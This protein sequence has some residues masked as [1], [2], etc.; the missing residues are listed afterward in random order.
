MNP[1][2]QDSSASRLRTPHLRF[3][4]KIAV[5]FLVIVTFLAGL[6]VL[7]PFLVKEMAGARIDR[8]GA[9]L[10]GVFRHDDIRIDGPSTL[11]LPSLLFQDPD[12]IEVSAADIKISVDPLA[13]LTGGR[14]ITAVEVGRVRIVAG[15]REEPIE[16]AKFA[17]RLMSRLLSRG[18]TVSAA[19]ETAPVESMHEPPRRSMLP[20]IRINS[21][22]GR[23]DSSIVSGE[24]SSGRANLAPEPGA[25]D[26]ATRTGRIE[27]TFR[28]SGSTTA[29]RIDVNASVGPGFRP[30][31]VVASVSPPVSMRLR[32]LAVQA[33]SVTWKKR[34]FRI[35]GIKASLP[36]SKRLPGEISAGQLMVRFKPLGP[37]DVPAARLVPS[38]IERFF[39]NSLML[40]LNAVAIQELRIA[41]P[42]L[43][44]AI[45]AG[46]GTP[47]PAVAS[48]SDPGTGSLPERITRTFGS[49]SQR[50]E[51][52]R[53]S[54]SGLAQKYTGTRLAVNGAT[55][56]YVNTPGRKDPISDHTLSNLDLVVERGSKSALLATLMFESPESSSLRNEATLMVGL[57]GSVDIGLSASKL[58]LEPY[59]ML[60]PAW[61][62]IDRSTAI[63]DTDFRMKIQDGGRIEASGRMNLADAGILIREIATDAMTSVKLGVSGT[64]TVDG[65]AGT[66]SMPDS[67]ASLGG[68]RIPFS[69]QA[70]GLNVRPILKLDARIDRIDGKTLLESIPAAA[71]PILAGTRLD[72]TF[73]A[74]M[75]FAVDTGNISGLL[76]DFTPDMADLVTVD[77]GP[78]I[79][80]ELLRSTFLHR[81]QDDNKVI[82][83]RIG[84]DSPGWVPYARIP[85]F[86]VRALIACEDA[87]FFSHEGF[88][89]A[90]IQRSL[91]VNLER[92][93][94][95]QGASTLSQQLVKNLFL[96]REKTLSRKLQEAFI[97]WQ[98]EKNL[99]KEKILE[100]YLNV[101][102]WG[103][104]VWGLKEAAN[105]YFGKDPSALSVLEAAF[106]VLIIPSPLKYHKFFEDGR[107]PAHFMKRIRELVD[108][109]HSRG[110]VSDLEAISAAQQGIRFVSSGT[111][112]Q[113]LDS[114]FSD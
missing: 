73:A 37:G 65:T 21:I 62:Q 33:D 29:W 55:I 64:A 60:L 106:L 63:T 53:S 72:G 52:L 82:V 105:H 77:L 87:R 83:R 10:K 112:A 47:P 36:D 24:L 1:D 57:D 13:M 4:R 5:V 84:S 98:V 41:R 46:D 79:N 51:S 23:I 19:R 97:T 31:S 110:A 109:L 34:E 101:I 95:F 11:F 59:R 81:I 35:D 61:L 14:K 8:A 99:P 40:L 108:T 49:I 91:K 93:G 27:I 66:I 107:V 18:D 78:A 17:G 22:V 44:L 39:P 96:S 71:I 67:V 50:A 9:S 42:V 80:L 74:G 25:V 70:S 2:A 38:D 90:G 7:V 88:S 94:F 12:G 26:A 68:I 30:D 111:P 3:P 58:L 15:S 69:F 43:D 54:L 56:R 103:P 104:D 32:G 114:E 76:F 100:L 89:K 86:L 28:P 113:V 85:P 45:S 20:D 48:V 92:G 102:E 16:P 6:A 75:R